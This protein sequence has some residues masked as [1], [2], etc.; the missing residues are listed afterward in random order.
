MNCAVAL[1]MLITALE[2][3]RRA[4]FE[5]QKATIEIRNII[6]TAVVSNFRDAMGGIYQH[7]AC[8]A[9]P[10]V[11]QTIYKG[12]TA[13]VFKEPAKRNLRHTG[14]FCYLGERDGFIEVLVQVFE[15][16]FYTTA[17]VAYF[18]LVKRCVAQKPAIP[19]T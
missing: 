14:E 10:Y 13:A 16:F 2:F 18:Y 9:K 1:V 6:K 3:A 17:V 19:G 15:C 7:A 12:F 5:L 4:V 8:M 11:V